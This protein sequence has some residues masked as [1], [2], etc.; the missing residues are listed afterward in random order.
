MFSGMALAL[1]R[2]DL[3]EITEYL[4]RHIL[5]EIKRGEYGRDDL[6]HSPEVGCIEQVAAEL[7]AKGRERPQRRAAR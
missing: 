1:P 2:P 4:A 6:R 7:N 3:A 5:R